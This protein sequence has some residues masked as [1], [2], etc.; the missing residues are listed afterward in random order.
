MRGTYKT[1]Q[2]EL[3]LDII[4]KQGKDF[5]IKELYNDVIREDDTIGQTTIYR[6]INLLASDGV[7]IKIAG[8]DDIVRYHLTEDCKKSGHCLLKCTV[9]GNLIH[10]DCKKL[11]SLEKHF[12]CEHNFAISS[13]DVVIYGICANCRGN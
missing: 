8:Q 4:A 2:K 6:M 11:N 3:I 5:T 9:C 1:K 7:L 13:D 10:A 12:M